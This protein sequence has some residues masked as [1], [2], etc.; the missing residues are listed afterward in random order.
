[1]AD[2]QRAPI[3]RPRRLA[4]LPGGQLAVLDASPDAILAVDADG[5]IAYANAQA[6]SAFGYPGYGLIGVSVEALLPARVAERHAGQ[7]ADFTESRRARPMGIGLDLRARRRDGTEFP[8]EIGLSPLETADGPIVFA[9]VVD[10]TARE[11]AAAQLIEA[12]RL[13]SIG[14]LA[15]GLAHDFGNMLFAIRGFAQILIEDLEAPERDRLDFDVAARRLHA[16][17]DAAGRAADLTRQLLSIS[18]RQ[19]VAPR[20]LGLNDAV[21]AIVPI[22]RRLVGA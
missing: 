13:E 11:A 21:R 4:D 16:I 19:V 8:A 12:R 2:R 7:R 6:G 10:T 20:G 15:G 9:T 5:V 3:R 1:M 14:R 22:L 18:Q 17:D